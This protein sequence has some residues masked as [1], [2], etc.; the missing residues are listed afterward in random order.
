MRE[1]GGDIPLLA[2][3]LAARLAAMHGLVSRPFANETLTLLGE[4]QWPGN[5]QELE[6]VT[7]RAL[8]LAT[9]STIAPEAIVLND[10]ARIVARSQ[11]EAP[12]EGACRIE[13]EA[14]VGRT[15]EEV[16]RE[17]ILQTLERCQGNRTSASMILGISVRTMRN[18][19][20]SFIEAGIP[21]APA[22]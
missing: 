3:H 9:G 2:R 10:G 21:V 18:K 19:L 7:H 6:N 5:V 8:L 12:A 11:H 14:L 4:H 22:L 13:V 17:L 16:E 20:R 1:R 15:V